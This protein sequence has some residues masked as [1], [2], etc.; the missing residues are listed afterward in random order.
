MDTQPWHGQPA[1]EVVQQ[2]MT[3]ER[4]W[5]GWS[6]TV[7]STKCL[8][9]HQDK[10]MQ[11]CRFKFWSFTTFFN[12]RHEKNRTEKEDRFWRRSLTPSINSFQNRS[13]TTWRWLHLILE[14]VLFLSVVLKMVEICW[15]EVGY[16]FWASKLNCPTLKWLLVGQFSSKYSA[17]K[18][19][20]RFS[21][22]NFSC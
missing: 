22:V 21:R 9:C 1:T 8:A 13:R 5:G 11:L 18:S 10:E 14:S 19:I 2:V 20:F 7:Y 16:R 3:I 15:R 12:P 6:V 17:R 4:S